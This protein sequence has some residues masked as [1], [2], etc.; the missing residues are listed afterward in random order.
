MVVSHESP[1]SLAYKHA[2]RAEEL[3]EDVTSRARLGSGFG[4]QPPRSAEEF[5]REAVLA[6]TWALIAAAVKS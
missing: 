6:S 3:H 4:E 5:H 2:R 1:T